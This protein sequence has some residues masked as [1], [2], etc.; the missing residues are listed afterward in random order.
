MNPVS[1]PTSPATPQTTSVVPLVSLLNKP[2]KGSEPRKH[3]P[4]VLRGMDISDQLPSKTPL[5][6]AQQKDEAIMY[7]ALLMLGSSAFSQPFDTGPHAKT[8]KKDNK[9]KGDTFDWVLEQKV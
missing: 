9:C 1:L 6:Q 4:R 3:K 5:G 2:Q 8:R 7:P